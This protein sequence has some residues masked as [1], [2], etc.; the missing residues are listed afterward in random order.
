MPNGPF[1]P[2]WVKCQPRNTQN[3]GNE[4]PIA[5]L[6]ADSESG[7]TDGQTMQTITLGGP[8]IVANQLPVEVFGKAV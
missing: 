8:H 2:E 4:L 1:L 6:M 7:Q 5:N 3:G